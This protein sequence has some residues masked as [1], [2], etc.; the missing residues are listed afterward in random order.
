MFIVIVATI[1]MFGIDVLPSIVAE[2]YTQLHTPPAG[3]A[4]TNTVDPDTDASGLLLTAL[5]VKLASPW[6]QTGK[7]TVKNFAVPD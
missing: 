4:G 3:R 5:N 7:L 6:L 1:G 2:R